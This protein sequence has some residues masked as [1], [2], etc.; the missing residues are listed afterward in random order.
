MGGSFTF[1]Q[2][3]NL[4]APAPDKTEAEKWREDLR[5]MAEEMPKRHNNLYHTIRREQF[6]AAV[7]RLYER[8]PNL[9]RHQIIIEMARIVAMVGDGHTGLSPTRDPKVGFRALPI[10]LYLFKDGL[11]VRAAESAH[12]DLVGARVLKIGNA[13]VDESLARAREIIGRDNEMDVKYFAPHLLI[14]PEVLHALGLIEEME[15]VSLTIEQGG[16][17]REIQLRPGGTADLIPPDTDTTWMPKPGWVDMRDAASTPLWLKNPTDKFWFEYLKDSRTVYAQLNQVG[18]KDTETL[19]DFSKRLLA[20][21]ESNGVEKLILDL[22]LNRGGNGTLLRPLE[23]AL[24]KSKIDQPG[25]LFTIMGRSTWSAAQFLL[26]RLEKY[27]N[28]IFVGEPSGSRGNVYGDSRKITLPN[29]GITVRVSVY[30]WQDWDPWDT[31]QWTAPHLTTELSS[32][33]YRTNADPALKAILDYVPRKRLLDV[34][35]EA[36]TAG[37]VELALKRFREFKMD[38]LNRYAD[39]EE[40]LLIAGQR[41]LDEKKPEQALA[42]FKLNAEDNPHSFRSYFA[43]GEAYFQTGNKEQAAKNL[44]RAL[45][46]NPKN[47]EVAERLRELKQKKL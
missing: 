1:A 31:R 35:N 19:A 21:V 11:F 13:T 24:I 45:E 10:K 36:L 41:L 17:R 25:K 43:L 30:Y 12:A 32:E 47:Y 18:N 33:D 7:A 38:A 8:I 34:L 39:T 46:L 40:P 23:I 4:K 42:L 15:K 28:T 9:A 6:E 26:N 27:T 3:E 2:G 29:S 44:E 16:V 22:R 14:M 5:Y 37:G 20:F